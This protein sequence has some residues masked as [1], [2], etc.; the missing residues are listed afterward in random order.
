M[1]ETGFRKTWKALLAFIVTARPMT[2]LCWT[3]QKNNTFIYRSA[4]LAEA[5]K[6]ERVLQQERHLLVVQRGRSLYNDMVRHAKDVCHE[7][8]ISEL[9]SNTPCSRQ[10]VM[11]YSFDYAQQVHLPSDPLQPGPIYFLVPRKVGLFGVC[12]EGVP[13]QV[14]FLIDEAHL[15]SKG[16]NAVIS[17]L[18]YFFENFGLGETEASLHCDNCPGKNK[19]R[20]VLWYCAWRVSIGLH[21]RINLNFLITGHT[22]FFPDGCFGLLKQAFRRHAVSS[23]E[24]FPSVVNGSARVNSA[25]L[26]GTED[27]TSYVPVGDWQ[28]HLS[29]YFRPLPGIKSFQHF[30]F[31]ATAPGKVFARVSLDSPETT[32][33]L[34][35]REASALPPTAPV[36]VSPAGMTPQRQWYLHDSIREFVR[37]DQKDILCPRPDVPKPGPSTVAKPGT[38]AT[39]PEQGTGMGKGSSGPTPPRPGTSATQGKGKGKGKGKSSSGPT[40]PK[41]S[42]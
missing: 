10:I 8:G 33:A 3:C 21:E 15:I 30:R 36:A 42:R 19:N 26:V 11:H 27:G 24:Q 34:L 23:L 5:E 9:T 6:S 16:S 4:N 41:R 14:N 20:F 39:A 29:P 18:H 1:S 2:D 38:S 37:E 7:L 28:S 40:P 17:F 22:K 25:Q 31:D 35:T 13:K 32:F 12:C